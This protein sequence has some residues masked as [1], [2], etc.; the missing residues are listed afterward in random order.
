MT[1]KQVAKPI[2][3]YKAQTAF[4]LAF[5]FISTL[6][7]N[8]ERG[9]FRDVVHAAEKAGITSE[10]YITNGHTLTEIQLRAARQHKP[11]KNLTDDQK[12]NIAYRICEIAL[13]NGAKSQEALEQYDFVIG[14]PA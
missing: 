2:F 6:S 3:T 4:D 10:M 13:R 9:H 5:K 7:D 14:H 1:E 8:P 12:R 11:I